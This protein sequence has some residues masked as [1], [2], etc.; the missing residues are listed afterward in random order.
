MLPYRRD[1]KPYS[2]RLRRA[3]TVCERRLWARL[4][5]KQVHGVQFYR[6]KPIG[7]FIVDFYAPAA[8]LVIEVDGAQHLRPAHA[9]RDAERDARSLDGVSALKARR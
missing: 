5:R 9:M 4:R 1:L 8:R 7:R 2:R 3:M 6:Q